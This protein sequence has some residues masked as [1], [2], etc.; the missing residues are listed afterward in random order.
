MKKGGTYSNKEQPPHSTQHRRVQ[1]D[2]EDKNKYTRKSRYK[3]DWDSW[4][5]DTTL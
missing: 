5:P 3:Q 2:H 4:F 1:K